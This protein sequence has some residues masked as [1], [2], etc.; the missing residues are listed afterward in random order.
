MSDFHS[1]YVWGYLM[2]VD[3]VVVGV[4]VGMR[5]R[6]WNIGGNCPGRQVGQGLKSLEEICGCCLTTVGVRDVDRSLLVGWGP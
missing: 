4:M 5:L 3:H 2:Q 1:E 6:G